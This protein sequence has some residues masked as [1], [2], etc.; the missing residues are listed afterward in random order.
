M[1]WAVC[2]KFPGGMP[3]FLPNIFNAKAGAVN[4]VT[5]FTYELIDFELACIACYH[6]SA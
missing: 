3:T 5:Y 1:Q 4:K 6:K 2:F